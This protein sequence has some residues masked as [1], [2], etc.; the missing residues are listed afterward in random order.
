M[1]KKDKTVALKVVEAKPYDAGRGIARIDPEVAY[2]LGLQTGDVIGIEGKKRTAAIIWPG[3]P[4]DSNSGAIRIDG[5]VRR[6]AGVSIDDRVHIRKIH[7]A[8]AQKI[9]FSPIQ[10]LK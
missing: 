6:N 4:E 10:P 8:P 2:D 5:T 9:L 1:D 7:T 3:Y